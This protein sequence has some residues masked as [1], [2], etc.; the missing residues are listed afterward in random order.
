MS[1]DIAHYGGI[2]RL[3][4]LALVLMVCVCL[5]LIGVSGYVK[6]ELDR[7]EYSLSSA[8]ETTTK[9]TDQSAEA[10]EQQIQLSNKKIAAERSFRTLSLIL[11]MLCWFSLIIAMAATLSIYLALQQKRTPALR[12]LAQSVG[13]LAKGDMETPVWGMERSDVRV[14]CLKP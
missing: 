8:Q 7:A 3:P 10:A 2:G 12:A 4:A 14:H 9:N 6:Y 13:N 1:K 11:T 5:S